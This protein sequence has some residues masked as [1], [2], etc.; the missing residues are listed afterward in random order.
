[1]C[2]SLAARTCHCTEYIYTSEQVCRSRPVSCLLWF[3]IAERFFFFFVFFLVCL[4][5]VVFVDLLS[6]QSHAEQHSCFLFLTQSGTELPSPAVPCATAVALLVDF[7]ASANC[8][9]SIQA[10]S[11]VDL[12]EVEDL[13]IQVM[14]LVRKKFGRWLSHSRQ[15][16]KY[17]P[18]FSNLREGECEQISICV[19]ENAIA[20]EIPKFM[21]RSF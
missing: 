18:N 5:L 13:V 11:T 2:Q 14:V 12:M 9:K 10:V 17:V 16:R 3:Q 8:C 7:S 4:F 20:E 1:M 19:A 15:A 21:S 6:K